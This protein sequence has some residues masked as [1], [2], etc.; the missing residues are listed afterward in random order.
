MAE[1]QTN[2][3]EQFANAVKAKQYV[4]VQKYVKN[5]ARRTVK[6]QDNELITL[7]KAAYIHPVNGTLLWNKTISE[8]EIVFQYIIMYLIAYSRKCLGKLLPII[9]L[10]EDKHHVMPAQVALLT[11]K[12]ATK[13][14]C[15][16]AIKIVD[17]TE[18]ETFI[19]NLKYNKNSDKLSVMDM[20]ASWNKAA[21]KVFRNRIM[22]NKEKKEFDKLIKELNK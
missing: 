7:L 20:R 1:I 3:Y 19:K 8:Q 6:M 12:S 15:D 18:R 17:K 13:S 4:A 11:S 9:L 16:A 22:N 21:G 10:G 14:I 2:E 5:Q